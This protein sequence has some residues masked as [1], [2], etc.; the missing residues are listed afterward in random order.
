MSRITLLPLLALGARAAS[1]TL[2]ATT[3]ADGWVRATFQLDA[4]GAAS[5]FFT[6][7]TP[8]D[9]NVSRI[10]PQPYPAEAP[11]LASAAQKWI[12]CASVP[13]CVGRTSFAYDFSIVNNYAT[14]AIH[15]FS[16]G[17][18][19]P[20]HLAASPPIS[21]ADAA[22]PSRGHLSRVPS[23]A[24][25]NVTWWAPAAGV[26]GAAVRWGAAPGA[27]TS[28]APASAATYSRAD[29]CGA[30]ATA[31]GWQEAH[32]WLTATMDGLAPGSRAP[33]YYSYGS[34]A[35]GWSAPASFLAPPAPGPAQTT[36]LLLLADNGVTEPDGCQDHWD[37]P[38]AS[39]TV[40]HLRQRIESGSGYDYSLIVHPG[41]V[42]YATGMLAKWATFTA[43]WGGVWDRVPYFGA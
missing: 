26:A 40:Q 18:E 33:V 27:L 6:V 1:I 41:D 24:A 15:A 35:T 31:M 22:A 14:S 7:H 9:A 25:M 39:L 29:M 42:S 30:P 36:R 13:G 11:W 4:P 3:I 28:S 32:F 10:A 5:D 20:A 23:A 12:S 2:N 8:A 38:S 17:L 34:D 16:G 37:E 21:F 43:R 19:A